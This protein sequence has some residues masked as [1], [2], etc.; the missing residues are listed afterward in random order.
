M[1]KLRRAK[2]DRPQHLRLGKHF[3]VPELCSCRNKMMVVLA[4]FT[5]FG[6]VLLIF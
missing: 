4:F 6:I 1:Q 3:D 5:A 2:R